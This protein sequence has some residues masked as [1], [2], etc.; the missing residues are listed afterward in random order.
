MDGLRAEIE[1]LKKELQLR[2]ARAKMAIERL[3]KQLASLTAERDELQGEVS[4]LTRKMAD[5]SLP[6]A[7]VAG[8]VAVREGSGEAHACVCNSQVRRIGKLPPRSVTFEDEWL[9]GCGVRHLLCSLCRRV[10]H[11]P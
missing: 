6:P 7:N 1:S 10:A 9:E 8:G 2:D 4:Y 11:Q 5:A 3:K